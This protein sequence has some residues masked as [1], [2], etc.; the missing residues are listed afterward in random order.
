MSTAP[1]RCQLRRRASFGPG[2]VDGR[3]GRYPQLHRVSQCRGLRSPLLGCCWPAPSPPGW[4]LRPRPSGPAPREAGPDP[5]LRRPRQH[6]VV[7]REG[8]RIR[9]QDRRADREGLNAKL[10]YVWYP[11]RRGYF[12]I[13]NGMYCD[14]AHRGPRRPR[15]GRRHQ[16]LLPL[17]L[18]VRHP[19]G[20]RARGPQVARRSPA[21]EARRSASTCYTSD[22]ENSPPAMALSR[23]GVVGNLTG[24]QHL[25]QR[26]G[27]ARGHHQGRGEQGRGPGHRV[28]PA[29]RLFRQAVRGAA[30]ADAASRPRT[31][32]SDI[33]FQLQHRAW[34]CAAGTR[35]SGT[36]WRRCST[37]K[38]PRDPGHPEAVRRPDASASRPGAMTTRTASAD[39]AKAAGPSYGG[40]L[41]H[42][43]QGL[44]RSPNE[45]NRRSP[46][47]RGR[48]LS[49]PPFAWKGTSAS[50]RTPLSAALRRLVA[51]RRPPRGRPGGRDPGRRPGA[52]RPVP[53]GPPGYGV[54]GRVRRLEAVQSELRPLSR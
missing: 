5:G 6:A 34:P 32:S 11:T 20:Q 54:P 51:G 40:H 14:M 8:R 19:P 1:G 36:A 3:P 33:P 49:G 29:R 39:A 41:A 46:P 47:P 28:G 38:A 43:V 27:P 50:M 12:R 4:P 17:R 48:R 42:R 53:S 18:R 23:Y 44:I 13:L 15:H 7:E 21:Q 16:A 52:S 22:A 30:E 10:E 25:L 24:Y 37:R 9:E 31:R 35:S 2:P 26:P 45:F